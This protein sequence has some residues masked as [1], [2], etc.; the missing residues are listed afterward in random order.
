MG[1]RCGIAALALIPLR[2]NWNKMFLHCSHRALVSNYGKYLG[3]HN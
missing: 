3:K 1:S 2:A